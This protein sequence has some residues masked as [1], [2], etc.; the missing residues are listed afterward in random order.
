MTKEKAVINGPP[1]IFKGPHR[2]VYVIKTVVQTFIKT[3]SR[4]NFKKEIVQYPVEFNSGVPII[5]LMR[6]GYKKNFDFYVKLENIKYGLTKKKEVETHV[7]IGQLLM[8][9]SLEKPRLFKKVWAAITDVYLGREY[10]VDKVVKFRDNELVKRVKALKWLFVMEDVLY[11][12]Y[13]GRAFLYN[14][15]NYYINTKNK[16]GYE[17][18]YDPGKLKRDLAKKGID[19]VSPD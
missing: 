17:K 7:E 16:T 18:Y 6:P 10:D 13:A 19:W 12:G 14:A 1:I 4:V 8:E 3:E 15:L 5:Y 11:W 2:R 9:L